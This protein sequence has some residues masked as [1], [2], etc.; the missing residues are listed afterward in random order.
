MTGG[1]VAHLSA[2]A[3]ENNLARVR[4]LA[5]ECRVMAVVKANAYGHGLTEIAGLLP[6]VDALAVARVDEGA[7]LREAG[8]SGAIVV[9]GGFQDIHDARACSAL[10]LNPVVHSLDQA[11]ILNSDLG[12]QLSAWI[13]VDSGM[14]RLGL[15]P[16]QLKPVMDSL[17]EAPGVAEILGV[18]THLSRA[19]E[20]GVAASAEQISVFNSLSGSW[21]GDISIANSAAIMS[22]E[23]ALQASRSVPAKA[24]NWVRPG[25]MLYG[26][27]PFADRSAKE[28]GLQPVM[29]LR[30]RILALRDLPKGT[31]VGYGGE[32][33]APRDSRVGVVS[34][35]Y[36]DGYPRRLGNKSEVLVHGQRAPIVGRVSMDSI[37]VDVSE[38]DNVA[39]GDPVVLWG[40]GLPVEEI[41][42]LAG[43]I[44][45]EILCGVAQ[46]V[47]RQIQA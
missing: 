3:L 24:R 4:Q 29:E 18:M 33:V 36:G 23:E 5:P 47:S 28:L 8:F 38:I 43:T 46:R 15:L 26:A 39:Q 27:S 6:S 30:S 41:A 25:L 44:A 14:G 19:D 12:G 37:S 13:K 21:S 1:L 32:W 10:A 34:A 17:A 35:G 42:E 45:Y 40:R 11:A 22:G 16:E 2:S 20:P 9:L 7:Q 31:A